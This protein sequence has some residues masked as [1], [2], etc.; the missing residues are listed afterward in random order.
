MHLLTRLFPQFQSIGTISSS[1][2]T[3]ASLPP[4]A[5]APSLH[6]P[7]VYESHPYHHPSPLY[8][9]RF[10]TSTVYRNPY[11]ILD[12]RELADALRTQDNDMMVRQLQ[13][14][15]INL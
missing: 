10:R 13:G 6:H 14:Y 9:P 1:P 15:K 3:S 11:D 4:L 8:P 2:A 7:T 12:G 5:P